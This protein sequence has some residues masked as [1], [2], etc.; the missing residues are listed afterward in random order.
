MRHFVYK[1]EVYDFRSASEWYET[2]STVETRLY[3]NKALAL[4]NYENMKKYV[5]RNYE[6]EN[7]EQKEEYFDKV[8][9]RSTWYLIVTG[10]HKLF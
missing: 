3:T 5:V 9:I 10:K 7:H 6:L 1:I 8:N 2:P 4:K